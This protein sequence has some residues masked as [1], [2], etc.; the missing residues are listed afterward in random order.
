LN[1][2]LFEK[3][4]LEAT[5]TETTFF[6]PFIMSSEQPNN[7]AA[8][9]AVS[10]PAPPAASAPA[11][12]PQT[13]VEDILRQADLLKHQAN[14]ERQ[15]NEALEGELKMLRAMKARADE[16]HKKVWEPRAEEFIKGLL[17]QG[18]VL[19]EE[20][21]AQFK[22]AFTM[23]DDRAK[24]GIRPLWEQHQK[25]VE[26]KAS[27]EAAR[28][29]AAKI[30]QEYEEKLRKMAEENKAAQESLSRVQQSMGGQQTSAAAPMRAAYAQ[31]VMEPAES[32]K[33]LMDARKEVGVN[34]S[35]GAAG[36][37]R[38]QDFTMPAPSAAE[39]PFLQHY[40]YT[41]EVSVVAS[42]GS[43][44]G[45]ATNQFQRQLPVS[46]TPAREHRLLY[47]AETKE[48]ALEGSMRYWNPQLF[49]WMCG[50]SGLSRNDLQD[51]VAIVNNPQLTFTE[52]RLDKSRKPIAGISGNDKNNVD[53]IG[54]L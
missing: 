21:K 23:N 44:V 13:P 53:M 15:R 49:D 47:D 4:N 52:E 32:E 8:A 17:E 10:Q 11:P 20:Q 26:L 50:K 43:T 39:L 54:L 22:R 45:R 27:A 30:K 12:V 16:E 42:N 6:V 46:F 9:A 34:A 35:K 3:K 51:H 2:L 31:A 25:T 37:L 36:S 19:S 28:A 18:T 7:A 5:D 24:E 14:E 29:E 1:N 38:L 48:P 41:S 33:L 40:G